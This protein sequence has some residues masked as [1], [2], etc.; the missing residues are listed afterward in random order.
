MKKIAT[1]LASIALMVFLTIFFITYINSY[2]STKQKEILLT[3][4]NQAALLVSPEDLNSFSNDSTDIEKASYQ[5]LRQKLINFKSFNK[6]ARFLYVLGYKPE[7]K[8][9]FFFI[10]AEPE[11]SKDYSPPGQIFED[12]RDFDI[13]MYQKGESYVD[14][15]HT[16]SWGSWYSGYSHVKDSFGNIVGLVG[17]DISTHVWREQIVFA[18][19]LV[20]IIGFF[21]TVFI[22][23]LVFS[24]R[25]KQ[26]SIDSLQVKTGLLS[27]KEQQLKDI[28]NMAHIGK[29]SIYFPEKLFAF[30]E[31]L[32]SLF[33]FQEN[34]KVSVSD[35]VN[36]IHEDDREKFN[37]MLSEIENGSA[38]YNW[39]DFKIGDHQK[40]FIK[41]KI[42]GS[43]EKSSVDRKIFSGIIQEISL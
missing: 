29:F 11:N 20:S 9:Q 43:V 30:D 2:I 25:K 21:I 34:E 27:K 18:T 6:E 32:S 28:Q 22:A 37:Q 35:F 41:Y 26:S 40:G 24:I 39:S 16:D 10:D 23:F 17:I 19:T 3:Q 42:S 15:P 31:E 12:T 5:N 36:R 4:A 14:G 38:V 8:K 7:I 13:K 1:I 33:S